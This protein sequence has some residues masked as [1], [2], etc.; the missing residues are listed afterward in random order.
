MTFNICFHQSGVDP[1]SNGTFA[2][3]ALIF[4]TVVLASDQGYPMALTRGAWLNVE[5]D[6]LAKSK[7]TLPHIA[8]T[9]FKLPGNSWGCYA[10]ETC[11]EKP[12]NT[13]LCNWI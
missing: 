5:A 3:I 7:V 4:A 11:I 9:S 10:G 1:L 6:C 2:S 8:P 12:F 13:S